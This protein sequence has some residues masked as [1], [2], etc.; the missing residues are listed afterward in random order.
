MSATT[1]AAVPRQAKRRNRSH[2]LPLGALFGVAWFGLMVVVALTVQ[3]LPIHDIA[4]PAG[5]SNLSPQWAREV[6]GT[7]EV[8]RS[9]LSR[10]LYGARTSLAIGLAA[11]LLGMVVGGLM[12]LFSVYFKG[13]VSWLVD[14]LATTVLAIPSLLFLLAIVLA[15]EPSIPVLIWSLSVITIPPFMRLAR[16]N[17]LSQMSSEYVEAAQVMGA[18]AGR[19]IFKELLPNAALPVISYAVLVLPSLI[20]VE[21]SL[22]FLGFGVQPPTPSWGGMIALA[23][24][25]LTTA[26]WG[27]F[28][29]C[30]VLFLTV[31][32]LNQIGDHLR[33]RFDVRDSNL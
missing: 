3:W 16:A 13:T 30:A 10:I 24:P 25:K 23:R 18:S 28:I 8:G 22:S 33:V 21:G 26:P 11:T 19:I 20:V 27:A 6:L 31:Y 32:S 9:V 5:P 15:L 12:G 1:A 7:D 29:P 17:A 4:T 14:I 2:R